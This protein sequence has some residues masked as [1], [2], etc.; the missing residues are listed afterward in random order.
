V[1]SQLDVFR[2]P[3]PASATTHPYL[4]VLQSD[5]LSDLNTRIVAP[6]VS[7]RKIPL[8]EKLMPLVQV[9]RRQY[10]IDVMN[11]GVIPV[12]ELA[13]YV[14]NLASE[15]ERMVQAVDLLFTGV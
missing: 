15:Y 5:V 1:P 10:V 7:P 12:R 8:F 13:A 9:E 2:N 6:L 3:D 4:I 14:T 11:L